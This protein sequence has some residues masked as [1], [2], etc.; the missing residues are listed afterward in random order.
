VLG[1]ALSDRLRQRVG[2][3]FQEPSLDRRMTVA[4][5]MALQAR[6][7][8]MPRDLAADRT[9]A[10]LRAT[11]LHERAPELTSTLSGGM[12]RRLELA[13]AL[14]TGPEILLLDEP[15]LALDLDS[16]QALWQHLLRANAGGLTMLV[17]TNDVHEAERY[18]HAVALLDHGRVVAEGVPA[19]LTR[20][21]RRDAVRIEWKAGH[22]PDRARI[23]AIEGAGKVRIAGQIAHVTVDDAAAFLALLFR[24]SGE[25]VHNVRIEESTLEDVYFQIVGHGLSSDASGP[26]EP[27]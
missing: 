24:D 25:H 17:A 1:E 2:I 27:S 3:V 7:F 15:T 22:P 26:D 16:R 4:E 18:C 14:V 19:D 12:R 10:L 8:G 5:T 13:R 11:G 6:L 20:E 9:T 23:Q 21:L